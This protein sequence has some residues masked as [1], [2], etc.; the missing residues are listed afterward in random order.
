MKKNRGTVQATIGQI[1]DILGVLAQAIPKNLTLEAAQKIIGSKSKL[2]NAIRRA[3]QEIIGAIGHEDLPAEWVR[4]YKEVFGIE[5]DFTDLQIPE[6]RE[7]FN[8][9][10]VM[11]KGLTS[12]KL[13]DKCKERF[14]AWRY[15]EDLDTVQSV[16]KTDHNYA[17]W[18]RDRVEAD[19]ENKNKSANVCNKEGINGITLEERLLLELWYHWKF[20]KHL[21]ISNWTLCSGS[22]DPSGFVPSVSWHDDRLSVSD[23]A[24]GYSLGYLRAR[25]AVSP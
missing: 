3:F 13:F 21:D 5:A 10:L 14:G 23:C 2:I 9:M 20:N 8:W 16:R 18:L 15:T 19:E 6:K 12:N 22:R 4:F 24:P 7:G 17:I 11:L 25:A 1:T